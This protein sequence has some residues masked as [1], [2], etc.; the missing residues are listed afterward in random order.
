MTTRRTSGVSPPAVGA[1]ATSPNTGPRSPAARN[2]SAPPATKSDGAL[3]PLSSVM[4]SA[5]PPNDPTELPQAPDHKGKNKASDVADSLG[6]S[7]Y[8]VPLP[9]DMVD[10]SYDL[11][12]PT[13]RM[14]KGSAAA[15]S[16]L[17]DTPIPSISSTPS[18]RS[19]MQDR[20]SSPSFLLGVEPEN[21]F[22]SVVQ[23]LGIYIEPLHTSVARWHTVPE[24]GGADDLL[25]AFG[26]LAGQ[27]PNQDE[28][29]SALLR[30]VLLRW[31]YPHRLSLWESLAQQLPI[32]AVQQILSSL[33][34]LRGIPHRQAFHVD[35]S[36]A[37]VRSLKGDPSPFHLEL[38]W[39]TLVQRLICSRENIEAQLRTLYRF[40]TEPEA[41]LSQISFDSTEGEL[42]SVYGT[43]SPRT[44]LAHFWRDEEKC[45]EL[46]V[47]LKEHAD[48]LAA[49][50]LADG[51]SVP[52]YHLN[53]TPNATYL[54]TPSAVYR[55]SRPLELGLGGHCHDPGPE[56]GLFL[57]IFQTTIE[58]GLLAQLRDQ[59]VLLLRTEETITIHLTHLEH[60]R[61][62]AA[63]G[64]P[65]MME[66]TDQEEG[67]TAG[68][69][70]REVDGHK[71]ARI[72]KI[73]ATWETTEVAII[74]PGVEVLLEDQTTLIPLSSLPEWNGEGKT[75][76]DYLTD[77]TSYSDLDE[78]MKS[79]IAQI[80]PTRFTLAA[81][82]WFTTLPFEARRVAT[83]SFDE[84]ILCLQEHFMDAHW[85]DERTIEYE[86]MRFRQPGH[87]REL[88]LQFIQRRLKYSRFLFSENDEND[89]EMTLGAE[90]RLET[91]GLKEELGKATPSNAMIR[92]KAIL[93][94]EIKGAGYALARATYIKIALTTRDGKR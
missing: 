23:A 19:L 67:M 36:Y 69:I 71:V 64:S 85:I 12:N 51:Y 2:S 94:P 61:K 49:S 18:L 28:E 82:D 84:F 53:P 62:L 91:S 7:P 73:L 86:E 22:V 3:P 14:I 13:S 55:D 44:E 80:A 1:K 50:L 37:F 42:C 41:R 52:S 68:Q 38:M 89:V 47:H 9:H 33:S 43:R 16:S 45:N 81:K 72:L 59:D 75:L 17:A 8:I 48:R 78:M 70:G 57:L 32:L 74:A 60:L 87:A 5:L 90:A 6:S 63:Q 83:S 10:L 92:K 39:E 65:R 4:P 46:P 20:S 77:L 24:L 54:R 30:N 93:H 88:P 27:L 29:I 56:L 34:E 31:R 35:P 15:P 76:I 66:A 21:L 79:D 26:G 40:F 11:A 25:N 58:Q